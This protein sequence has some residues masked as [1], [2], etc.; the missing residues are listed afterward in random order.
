MRILLFIFLVFSTLPVLNT[1]RLTISVAAV[2]SLETGLPQGNRTQT[3]EEADLKELSRGWTPQ[4]KAEFAELLRRTDPDTRA[5]LIAEMLRERREAL[6]IETVLV[7]WRSGDQRLVVIN[8]EPSGLLGQGLTPADLQTLRNLKLKG[9]LEV[10]GRG[11]DGNAKKRVRVII[12]M[13]HQLEQP[14]KFAVPNLGTVICLQLDQEWKL[15]PVDYQKSKKTLELV[16]QTESD[17][18]LVKDDAGGIRSWTAFT[19]D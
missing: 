3:K 8:D 16:K 2:R 18:F 12:V 1:E 14:F 11:T 7:K 17:T 5:K 19:W 10:V 9:T 4:Q 13:Q 6:T 15:F